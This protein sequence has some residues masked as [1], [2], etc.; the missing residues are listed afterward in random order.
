LV[1]GAYWAV[2]TGRVDPMGLRYHVMNAVGAGL[3][4]VSLWSRPNL[5]AAIVEGLWFVIA[6]ASIL[7]AVRRR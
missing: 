5:G 3:L 1:C 6:M 7:R 4:L 2:S